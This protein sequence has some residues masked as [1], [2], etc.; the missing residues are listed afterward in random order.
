MGGTLLDAHASHK[1]FQRKDGRTPPPT[2]EDPGNP[3]VNFRGE[4]R[5]NQPHRSVTGP[6]TQL[7][8]KGHQTAAMLCQAA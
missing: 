7:A 8:R 6:D 5:S 3:T 1:S 4:K 2:D